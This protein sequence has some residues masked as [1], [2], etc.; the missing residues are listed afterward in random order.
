MILDELSNADRYLPMH[1][2]FA[3][4]IEQLRRPDLETLPV[5]SC[6]ID[7]ERL[8]L[9]IG[10]DPGRGREGAKLEAHRRYID[11]Q[12]A[13]AGDEQIGW[14]PT[15]ECLGPQDAF[16]TEHD[17]VLFSDRPDCWLSVTPGKFAV[18]YPEDAHAPLAGEGLLHKAVVKVAVEW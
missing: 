15:G 9:I 12:F 16:C 5:G 11:I 18:F 3:A 13:I 2:G 14:R 7:G 8:I 17:F 4:G 6:P 1:P 10:Q